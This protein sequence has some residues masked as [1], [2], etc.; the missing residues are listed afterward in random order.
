VTKDK[1]DL[2]YFI[3]IIAPMLISVCTL[4]VGMVFW[5]Q[6]YGEDHFYDKER[7]EILYEQ[8]AR[9]EGDMRAIREQNTQILLALG[10]VEGQLSV[11]D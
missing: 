10:R 8:Q 6:S 5:V 7:G 11:Q 1:Y 3:K 9:L 4:A 2:T